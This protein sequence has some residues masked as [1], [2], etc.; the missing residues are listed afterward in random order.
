[1]KS[2]LQRLLRLLPGGDVLASCIGTRLR[3]WQRFRRLNATVRQRLYP[4]GADIRVL[5]GSFAG[6]RYFDRIVWGIISN[7]W[8]GSY[9]HELAPVVEDIVRS[10]CRRVLDIGCA[11]GWYLTGL[12]VRMSGVECIGFDIDPV[13]RAQS[14]EL[15]RLNGVSARVRVLD[16]CSHA[17]LQHLAGPGTVLI[18]DIEGF[19][20]VLLDPSAAPVLLRTDI[21]VEVHE[22]DGGST[23]LNQLLRQRFAATHDIQETRPTTPAAWIIAHRAQLPAALDDALALQAAN[24]HRPQGNHWLWMKARSRG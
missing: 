4:D 17:D 1:M 13:S 12:A 19:E 7:K 5:A 18:S 20:A 10:G 3:S 8:L 22:K 21:L 16:A 14:R 2:L 24:E 23:A 11:E 6:M 9:E 15:A